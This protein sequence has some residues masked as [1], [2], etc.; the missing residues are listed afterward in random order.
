M[1]AKAT[2]SGTYVAFYANDNVAFERDH[3]PVPLW[4]A[5]TVVVMNVLSAVLSLTA[6]AGS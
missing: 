6:W 5:G 2:P 3:P 4:F 1:T